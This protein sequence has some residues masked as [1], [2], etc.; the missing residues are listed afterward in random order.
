MKHQHTA[1]CPICANRV[2]NISLDHRTHIPTLQNVTLASRSA[3]LEFPTGVLTMTRC[4]GCSFVWNAAFDP[5]R[6]TYDA[7]YNNDVTYSGYYVAH[8]EAMADRII[9][10][11]AADQPIHYVE[12]GCGEADFLRLVVQRARGRCV[13]ATGFDPSYAGHTPLPE[14]AIVHRSFFG[15]DQLPQ[16]PVATNVICSRHTIEHVPDVHAFVSALCAPMQ[17][18]ARRLFI[19][20]PD[21]DWILRNTAFQDFF[22]EHCSIFTPACM[23]RILG[24][25]GLS[26]QTTSVYGGQYMW[27]EAQH[28]PVTDRPDIPPDDTLAHRYAKDSTELIRRWADFVARNTRNGPVAIWGAASKGVTFSLLLAQLQDAGANITCAI[29]LNRAKQG[30]YLPVSGAPVVSPVQAQKIGVQSIIVMNPNYLDEIT[31][32][33]DAM[34]WTPVIAT[35]N[36]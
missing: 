11:V 30:C 9:A 32:M 21:A 23:A 14:G 28:V 13:S 25:Y 27:T 35:L 29:D 10:A 33:V 31:K 8:L 36:T 6:I 3:A 1:P 12:V 7:A 16:I 22:Y 4:A 15:P 26:A 19:E 2:G 24:Q 18:P 34:G 5:A 20:T 17:D